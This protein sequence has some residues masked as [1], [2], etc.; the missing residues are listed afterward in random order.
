MSST[1]RPTP[2]CENEGCGKNSFQGHKLCLFCYYEFLEKL[3]S[4]PTPIC[5][6]EH[7]EKKCYPGRKFCVVCCWKKLN[8]SS[9]P[10][11]SV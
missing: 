7:C 4:S 2:I 1:H 6:N 11:T 5:E 10:K 3:K 9:M 8:S